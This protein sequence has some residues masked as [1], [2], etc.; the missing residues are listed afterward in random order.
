MDRAG[1]R[2][3]AASGLRAA[4]AGRRGDP[5]DADRYARDDDDG[6]RSRES[7]SESDGA[8]EDS[9]EGSV[10]PEDAELLAKLE[11]ETAADRDA[12]AEA[13]AAFAK[14]E[15]ARRR[16]PLHALHRFFA[17]PARA[18][19][20]VYANPNSLMTFG[21]NSDL[22][23]ACDSLRNNPHFEMFIFVC[24]LVN[25]VL[26]ALTKPEAQLDAGANSILPK[27][28]SVA[29][30]ATFVV[31]FTL[32][33]LVKIVAMGFLIGED[34]YLRHYWNMLDF[35]VV[36]AGLIDLI[37]SSAGAALSPLR[38]IRTLQPLRA[39]NKFRS[40]RLVLE[41]LGASLPL[42]MDV[43]LFMLWF[44]VAMTVMGVM[45]FG[46]TM[47]FRAFYPRSESESVFVNDVVLNEGGY[48]R[49]EREFDLARAGYF[50]KA[51]AY[52]RQ[53]WFANGTDGLERPGGAESD[54]I[55]GYTVPG[56]SELCAWDDADRVSYS[57]VNVSATVDPFSSG[58][59]Q[60]GLC[61]DSDLAPFDDYVRF[62]NFAQGVFVVL[63]MMTVDGWNEVTWPMCDANGF[64]KPFVFA[65]VVVVIGGF[66][67]IQ[68][69]TSVI[70]ATLGDVNQD[71]DRV[72]A[73]TNDVD[74]LAAAT[75][76]LSTDAVTNSETAA[77][78]SKM[79]AEYRE[80]E[81]AT[82]FRHLVQ[83]P[84]FEN[85]IMACIA[86]NSLMMITSHYD[87]AKWYLDVTKHAETAFTIIFI[88][89]FSLKHLG[90][91]VGGYWSDSWN[92]LDG[93]IVLSSIVELIM[94]EASASGSGVNLSFLRVFRIFRI[95]RTF[96]V[97]RENKEFVRILESAINGVQAMWVFL[98]VWALLLIIFAILGVQ[99]FGGQGDLDDERLGFKDVGAALLTLFVVSTGENTFEV[100]YATIVATDEWSGLYMIAWLV[101]S[102]AVLSLI[103]GILI[104]SIT[105]EG[106][107]E[108]AALLEAEAETMDHGAEKKRRGFAESIDERY[109]FDED[110]DDAFDDDVGKERAKTSTTT[111]GK[112]A[113]V[114]VDPVAEKA[115][116]DAEKALATKLERKRLSH[117]RAD[118]AVVRR[119]LVSIG[120]T[121]HTRESLAA[122]RALTPGQRL[123][124]R[125]RMDAFDARS[126]RRVGGAVTGIGSVRKLNARTM[127]ELDEDAN[128][129]LAR[130]HSNSD[131][132]KLAA[133]KREL[134]DRL[135]RRRRERSDRETVMEESDVST[136][137]ITWARVRPPRWKRDELDIVY[138]DE[139]GQP[140]SEVRLRREEEEFHR[141]QKTN[142]ANL[143][144]I[145]S[146]LN[147]P[148]PNDA[149]S[150]GDD[151]EARFAALASS[152]RGGLVSEASRKAFS[153]KH[154]TESERGWGGGFGFLG[155]EGGSARLLALRIATHPF[156]ELFILLSIGVSSGLL[157]AETH[158]FPKSGTS[159]ATAFIAMDITFTA[160]F[161]GEMVLKM[162]AFQV[163]QN[164]AAYLRSSFN[165]LDVVV[166]A[167]SLLTLAFGS[168]GALRSLRLLRV[169]RPLRS[170]HK[171][172]SLKLVINAVIAS[173]PAISHVCLL[174]L[175]LGTV[176]S[177]MG[178]EL[179][180][181]K[182]WYCSSVPSYD[183]YVEAYAATNNSVA[184]E[185]AAVSGALGGGLDRAACAAAGGTWRNNKFNFDNFAEAM[186]SVFVISTGDNWQ[187]IMYV[188]MDSVGDGEAPSRDHSGWAAAYFVLVVLVA[189]LFWANLFVSAL[190]DNFN[191]MAANGG[192]ALVSDEQR[193]WQQAMQLATI[194]H[195]ERWRL[196]PPKSA[197]KV[198]RTIHHYCK[199]PAFDNV[200]TSVIFLNLLAMVAYRHD[201]TS[202]EMTAQEVFDYF[203]TFFYILEAA[204]LV[205]AMGWKMYWS[206][207]MYR[208][209]FIVALVG[210]VD[211]AVPALRE[212]GFGDAFRV[213]RFLRLVK[214][215]K[216]S[217]GLR[218]LSLTFIQSL[219]AV[220]NIS[221]LSALVI[222]I[223][224]CLGVSLYGDDQGPF[225]AL[226][227]NLALSEYGN[228]TDFPRAFVVLFVSY[229]GNWMSYFSDMFRDQRCD[230]LVLPS[231]ATDDVTGLSTL[232]CS[233]DVG[234]IFY[235]FS[236]VVIAI[237]LLANLFVA[238]IL[239]QF[240]ACADKEGVFGGSGIV[241]L[242]ITTVQLRKIAKLIKGRV[243]RHRHATDGGHAYTSVASIGSPELKRIR[244]RSLAGT[245]FSSDESPSK[246]GGEAKEVSEMRRTL[247][248]P[249]AFG[250]PVAAQTASPSITAEAIKTAIA[251]AANAANA[252]RRAGAGPTAPLDAAAE[253][254]MALV[255]G[256]T[257]TSAAG[258]A[259]RSAPRSVLG[260]SRFGASSRSPASFVATPAADGY[261]SDGSDAGRSTY[262]AA[263]SQRGDGDSDE[264]EESGGDAA[265]AGYR[266]RR[267]ERRGA[268]YVRD[269]DI[270]LDDVL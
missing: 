135:E 180:Q 15:R 235:A 147:V 130:D 202:A 83:H 186:V 7:A 216:I 120:E 60:I 229:T 153:L 72:V 134:S 26:I 126:R 214:L 257:P 224:A 258:G 79:D 164:R 74:A 178:M 16:T 218:T 245:G 226:R 223:Y 148:N 163:Y 139:D 118:V 217:R 62:D 81:L 28:T 239:E 85:F 125:K 253:A 61:C 11:A 208:V 160:L 267:R 260:A 219:P 230:S 18:L 46:G 262:S 71:D 69:F 4:P 104:D 84:Y 58:F 189:M 182:M 2:R 65:A 23:R 183:A 197:S 121:S 220:V 261:G 9:E 225:G 169:L 57:N 88:V 86:L 140:K 158:T 233:R 195:L 175:G 73:E 238:V 103:L 199:Q 252:N 241:D 119:W 144:V 193:R 152:P 263:P 210:F 10:S 27:A 40:G 63:Q 248:S 155:L 38:L 167:A 133:M 131:E 1:D 231:S 12:D 136:D 59:T 165:I 91:G 76:G 43:V 117:S 52:L 100:A 101:I 41:T 259:P 190:V 211:F 29:L 249:L 251:E 205:A 51:C 97:L 49:T 222:F 191:R 127:D 143:R 82:A 181:G 8:S 221:V 168:V 254:V 142:R 201:A 42:L 53:A 113:R 192:P 19:E 128:L 34:C 266:V 55:A 179:F 96:R 70:C 149:F 154:E 151:D 124:A 228:F 21:R 32:E 184:L 161:A 87:P 78:M 36:V 67:I 200:V 138:E 14:M 209:D 110:D 264:D 5:R 213:A 243:V 174:G 247:K 215:I 137:A 188:A 31:I 56:D 6:A 150:G 92:K 256:G 122:E 232:S 198:R 255:S 109:A 141:E 240:S 66:V 111:K 99:L 207:F 212:A 22:R 24:V 115:R 116:K 234:S 170:V 3:G 270:D 146:V 25:G 89:E 39:L 94:I 98:V 162:Y 45:F 185:T 194:S 102:T 114:L 68:L 176:L 93:F 80:N 44:V 166:V 237:F 171:L 13:M 145:L 108:Q 47:S 156:F 172:P 123:A 48:G 17:A 50:P 112:K 129:N 90:L 64:A 242:V 106:D 196:A 77:A 187:D 157:A 35:I 227:S 20:E 54:V 204:L 177:I 173:V 95:V 206:N 268:S 203:F 246:G 159:A 105:A 30:Q 132:K 265:R 107:E 37:S 33:A 244:Q 269:D 250:S 75:I 236:F